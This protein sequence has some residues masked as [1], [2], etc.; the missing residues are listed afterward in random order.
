[1]MTSGLAQGAKFE[2]ARFKVV[3]KVS[4]SLSLPRHLAP[5]TVLSDADVDNAH[6]PIPIGLSM[7]PM[8]PRLNGR[9]F[10]MDKVLDS[11]SVALGSRKKIKIFH[12]VSNMGMMGRMMTM[13]HPVHLHGQQY[14]VLSRKNVAMNPEHYASVKDGL[15]RHAWKDTILVMPGEEVEIIKPFDDYSG[16]FLYHCHNLEHE[17]LGMMRQFYVS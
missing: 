16:L 12:E 8:S 11:E 5:F 15:I 13:A 7:A 10:A 9:S 1:M 2:I 14:Q 3:E 17:D 6:A 4:D